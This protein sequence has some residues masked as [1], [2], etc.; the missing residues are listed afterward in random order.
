MKR[1][2]VF[3][4]KSNGDNQFSFIKLFNN[5]FPIILSLSALSIGFIFAGIFMIV[6]FLLSE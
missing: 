5:N 1:L 3:D 4:N 6:A 2:D